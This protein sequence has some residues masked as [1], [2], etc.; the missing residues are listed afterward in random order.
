MNANEGLNMKGEISPEEQ[1]LIDLVIERAEQA[2]RYA[3]KHQDFSED[4]KIYGEG[5]EVGCGVCEA[6]IRTSVMN[7]IAQ[8]LKDD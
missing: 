3:F 6:A 1:K 5:F 7:H 2:C 8:D 4:D